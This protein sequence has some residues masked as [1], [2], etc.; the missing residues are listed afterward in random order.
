MIFEVAR[1]SGLGMRFRSHRRWPRLALY[2]ALLFAGVVWLSIRSDSASAALRVSNDVLFVPSPALVKTACLGFDNL[3]SDIFWLRTVRYVFNQQKGHR[4]FRMLKDMLAVVTGLDPYPCD[5]YIRGGCWLYEDAEDAN[6][7]I[8]F[9][10]RGLRFV[11]GHAANR[12]QIA[13]HIGK[14]FREEL[15]DEENATHYFEM[16][17]QM[18]HAPRGLIVAVAAGY[19]RLE[20]FEKAKKLWKEARDTT[21]DPKIRNAANRRILEIEMTQNTIGLLQQKVDAFAEAHGRSP[22]SLSEVVASGLLDTVP[23]APLSGE[24][25]LDADSGRVHYLYIPQDLMGYR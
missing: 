3:L 20:K 8:G 10:Q 14:C 17:L 6:D 13:F 11:P 12:W 2:L 15:H 19:Q 9:L 22:K 23:A 24:Y 1:K 18:P 4:R 25:E 7:G 16:A 5:V 21:G